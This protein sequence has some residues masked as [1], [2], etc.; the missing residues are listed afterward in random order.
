MRHSRQADTY[1]F[2]IVLWEMLTWEVPWDDLG[3]FQVRRCTATEA[4]VNAVRGR[5]LLRLS[6]GGCACASVYVCV[7]VWGGGLIASMLVAFVRRWIASAIY[8]SS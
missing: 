8:I 4:F 1:A 5:A 7:W 2:G 6:A 3:T